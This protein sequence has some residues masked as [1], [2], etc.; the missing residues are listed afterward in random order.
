MREMSLLGLYEVCR[1]VR[2]K[3]ILGGTRDFAVHGMD[4]RNGKT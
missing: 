3:G 4:T 1:D 2:K